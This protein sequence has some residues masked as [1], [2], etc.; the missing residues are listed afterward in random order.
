MCTRPKQRISLRRLGGALR[1][2]SGQA[3]RHPTTE[4]QTMGIALLHPSYELAHEG[5]KHV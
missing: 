2:R 5:H 4:L 3:P 1:L